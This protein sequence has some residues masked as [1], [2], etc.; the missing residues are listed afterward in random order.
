MIIVTGNVLIEKKFPLF[1]TSGDGC[2][3]GLF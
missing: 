3:P 2:L 1:P